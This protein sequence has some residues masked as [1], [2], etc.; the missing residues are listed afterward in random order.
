[1]IAYIEA[2]VY[3]DL[4][5]LATVA[6]FSPPHFRPVFKQAAGTPSIISFR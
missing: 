2:H 4:A 6:G 1:M 5:E 3:E